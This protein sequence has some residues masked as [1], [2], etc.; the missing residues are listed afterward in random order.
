MQ[1]KL[2]DGSDIQSITARLIPVY[3][4]KGLDDVDLLAPAQHPELLLKD[5]GSN[6]DATPG[7]HV[8]SKKIS[9]T[10]AYFYRVEIEAEDVFGNKSVE[11]GSAIFLVYRD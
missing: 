3:D 1:V 6:G 4:V 5:E 2:H 9:T 8:F 7:D 11:T 10:A